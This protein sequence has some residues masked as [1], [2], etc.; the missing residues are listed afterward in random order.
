MEDIMNS[1]QTTVELPVVT[2]RA[3]VLEA[4][5]HFAI[6]V[7]MP[8]V[9]ASSLNLSVTGRD[10]LVEGRSAEEPSGSWTA[11]EREFLAVNYRRSFKLPE[12]IQGEKVEAEL[13][14]GVVSIRIPKQ[15][16]QQPRRI[17]VRVGSSSS[18]EVH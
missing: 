12:G 11:E 13:R 7:E 9:P 14:S 16:A 17:P 8:G 6:V 18:S 3:E 2:P 1:E 4:P 10:L 15:E 5:T